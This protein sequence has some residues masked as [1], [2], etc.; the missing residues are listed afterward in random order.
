MVLWNRGST[1]ASITASWSSIGLNASTVADAHDLW[2]VSM[3]FLYHKSYHST[4]TLLPFVFI[5]HSLT[6]QIHALTN[7]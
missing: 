2:T 4:I 1:E 5:M 6:I 7:N 3:H